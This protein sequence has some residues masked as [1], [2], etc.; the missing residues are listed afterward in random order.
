MIRVILAL[1]L[2]VITGVNRCG[3]RGDYDCGGVR[4]EFR[5]QRNRGGV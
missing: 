4:F 2:F 1:C 3:R 5:L